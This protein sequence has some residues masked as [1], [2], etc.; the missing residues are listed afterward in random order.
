[1]R[2][3]IGRDWED[4]VIREFCEARRGNDGPSPELQREFGRLIAEHK[5]R[6]FRVCLG[7]TG[8]EELSR[9]LTEDALLT[10]Y[11][12]L[13]QSQRGFGTWLCGIAKNLSRNA[14]RRRQDFLLEDGI[15]E[16]EDVDDIFARADHGRE[17]PR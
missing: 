8:D 6:V 14:V 9:E 12:K 4:R 3:D 2:D 17:P 5:P 15:L 11:N 10:A 16:T 13:P 7:I 1:L